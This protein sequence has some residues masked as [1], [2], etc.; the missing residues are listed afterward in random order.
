MPSINASGGSDGRMYPASFESDNEKKS[1][2]TRNQQ[3]RKTISGFHS[4]Q[5]RSAAMGDFEIS[6]T[7]Q[8]LQG[9]TSASRTGT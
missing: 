9:K 4:R 6:R 5:R 7:S 1:M 2:G 3:V 8:P